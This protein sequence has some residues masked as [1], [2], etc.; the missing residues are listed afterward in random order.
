M[1]NLYVFHQG[2]G[3]DGQLLYSVFDGTSWRGDTPVS[4]LGM[5]E[6]PSAV[7]WQGGISVFHQ[8]YGNNAQLWYAYSGDGYHW[9]TAQT[10][11]RVPVPNL[12]M[13]GAPSV[14]E[15]NGLLYIFFQGET[16]TPDSFGT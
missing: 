10:D 11:T 3:N 6:S 8:G 13:S 9:G 7:A 14:V 16:S 4:N 12:Q 2:G 1:A 15:Y 5:S